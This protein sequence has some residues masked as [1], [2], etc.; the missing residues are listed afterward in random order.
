MCN[1]PNEKLSKAEY[2]ILQINITNAKKLALLI[3]IGFSIFHW[4][5]HYGEYHPIESTTSES[6]LFPNLLF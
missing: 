2:L 5:L 3:V 6:N 4:I 1:N